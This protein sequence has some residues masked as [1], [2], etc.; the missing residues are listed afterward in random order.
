MESEDDELAIAPIW[1]SKEFE[2]TKKSASMR[3]VMHR[4][5][6]RESKPLEQPE[7]L[8][9]PQLTVEDL[10]ETITALMTEHEVKVKNLLEEHEGSKEELRMQLNRLREIYQ[11]SVKKLLA[12]IRGINEKHRAWARQAVGNLELKV[13][14][15]QEEHQRVVALNMNLKRMQEMQDLEVMA[16]RETCRDLGDKLVDQAATFDREMQSLWAKLEEQ[17]HT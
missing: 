13:V 10:Q 8:K 5:E 2:R 3:K 1:E 6:M 16:L 17:M 14:Q 4:P 9:P 15:I 12:R 11:A 7:R